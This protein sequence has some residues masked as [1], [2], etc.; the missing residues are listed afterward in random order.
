MMAT[1]NI[2]VPEPMKAWIE[3]EVANGHYASVSDYI[4]EL[5]RQR[6]EH[7]RSLDAFNAALEEGRKSG[8]ST[9]S[10]EDIIAAERARLA[11]S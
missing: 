11:A 7:R 5:V 1:M 6:I 4:R 9:R 8:V 2:S 3:A 10:V